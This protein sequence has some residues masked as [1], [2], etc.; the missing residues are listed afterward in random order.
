MLDR[1][2]LRVLFHLL[3]YTFIDNAPF[4]GERANVEMQIPVGSFR[5]TSGGKVT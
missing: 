3:K 1:L 2:G 4:V 5:G